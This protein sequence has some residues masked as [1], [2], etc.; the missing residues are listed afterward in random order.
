MIWKTL[1]DVPPTNK[2]LLLMRKGFLGRVYS[3]G[4]WDGDKFV[5]RGEKEFVDWWCEF[6]L[7]EPPT[8]E[9]IKG[10]AGD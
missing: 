1:D 4:S 3:V 6:P 10:G 5:V 8:A 2:T 9:R 7:I